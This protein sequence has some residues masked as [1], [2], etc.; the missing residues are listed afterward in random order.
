MENANHS[1]SQK[2]NRKFFVV[3]MAAS[4]I[5]M[6]GLGILQILRALQSET[7]ISEIDATSN[8][9]LPVDTP[10]YRNFGPTREV[11]LTAYWIN[12]TTNVDCALLNAD[13]HA[14]KT[15]RSNS[16]SCLFYFNDTNGYGDYYIRVVYSVN[17]SQSGTE[18]KTKFFIITF[19]K[20]GD[21]ID[22]K[23]DLQPAIWSDQPSKVI[24]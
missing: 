13:F 3:L 2:K 1:V 24:K 11:N 4:I 23:Y 8:L 15:C 22:I 10:D 16:G 5:I 7:K 18:T 21:K 12:N 6:S 14:L 17:F 19:G 9:G 20:Y